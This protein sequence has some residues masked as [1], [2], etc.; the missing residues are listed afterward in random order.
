MV[1]IRDNVERFGNYL[2]VD[3]MRSSVCDAKEL[4]YITLVVLHE[5]GKINV[6][7]EGFLLHKLM[8]HILLI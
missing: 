2:S 4:C 6:V 8:I 1:C 7:Y 5:I 3:V